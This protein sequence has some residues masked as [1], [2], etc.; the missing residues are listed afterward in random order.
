MFSL[1][2]LFFLCAFVVQL[3]LVLHFRRIAPVHP[4]Q[5]HNN[6]HAADTREQSAALSGISRASTLHF[7]PIQRLTPSLP[8]AISADKMQIVQFLH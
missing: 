1:H 7:V 2:F 8:P 3:H 5:Q 6:M 4:L